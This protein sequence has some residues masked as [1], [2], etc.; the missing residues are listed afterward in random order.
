MNED[1]AFSMESE[2]EYWLISEPNASTAFVFLRIFY[3]NQM[4]FFGTC[5]FYE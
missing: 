3:D 5:G 2:D 1:A 4:G